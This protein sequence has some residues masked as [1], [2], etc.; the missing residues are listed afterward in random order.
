L[1]NIFAEKIGAFDSFKVK[2]FENLIITL[3][4]ENNAIF[5]QKIVK[6][7]NIDPWNYGPT[8]KKTLA[9]AGLCS[10][11][12]EFS[13]PEASSLKNEFERSPT[14]ASSFAKDV[15]KYLNN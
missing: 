12:Q 11:R 8:H 15:K 7:H 3:A 2:L 13:E 10:S 1:K 5:S 4:W 14:Y 9:K 6:K